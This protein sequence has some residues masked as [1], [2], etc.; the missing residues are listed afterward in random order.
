MQYVYMKISVRIEDQIIELVDD[1]FS[2]LVDGYI[3]APS[4]NI[5]GRRLGIT[6]LFVS[7]FPI[8]IILN[9]ESI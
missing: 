7:P 6:T 2:N 1:G 9:F 4:F 3:H 8:L 5:K